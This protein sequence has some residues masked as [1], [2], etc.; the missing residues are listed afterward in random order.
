MF[1]FFDFW[2][3]SIASYGRNILVVMTAGFLLQTAHAATGNIYMNDTNAVPDIGNA[4]GIQANS[5][6]IT[7]STS[8]TVTANKPLH[9]K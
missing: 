7:L 9:W 5:G 2:F 8:G 1:H 3:N 6:N 4:G